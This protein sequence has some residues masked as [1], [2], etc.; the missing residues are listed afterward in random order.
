MLLHVD[1]EVWKHNTKLTRK[2]FS[3]NSCF[4]NHADNSIDLDV[5]SAPSAMSHQ[6][7]ITLKFF[8]LTG[9]PFLFL[10]PTVFVHFSSVSYTLS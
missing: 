7:K 3:L 5:L 10:P 1:I 6:L 4:R 8:W 9:A 2:I